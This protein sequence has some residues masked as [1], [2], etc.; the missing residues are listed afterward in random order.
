MVL[1][2]IGSKRFYKRRITMADKNQNCGNDRRE[3]V[4]I[5][6][7]R[8]LDSCLDKE[9]LTDVR[10]YFSETDQQILNNSK[11][12]RPVNAELIWTYIDVE[13]LPF[14]KGFYTVDIRYYFKCCFDAY[15]GV[16]H[17]TRICGLSTYD[18]RVI[19][20]GS[21]GGANIYSSVFVPG[22]N[23]I[24]LMMRSN[25]PKATVEVVPPILLAGKLVDKNVRCG[26]CDIDVCSVPKAVCC[27]F[28]NPICDCTENDK[29][30]YATLGLFSIIR[31]MR[32]VQ[33]VVPSYDFCIPDKQCCSPGEDD[34]CCLFNKMDFPYNDFFPPVNTCTACGEN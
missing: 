16:M 22:E 7:D 4:C 26:C 20:F 18:K 29:R 13:S 6:V 3:T 21:E 23:D 9:C 31:L 28:E 8:V 15:A 30:L 10:V 25:L 14:N 11:S 12:V 27:C 33:I 2:P 24:E 34:P 32:N 19:L 1:T 17:P 5:D